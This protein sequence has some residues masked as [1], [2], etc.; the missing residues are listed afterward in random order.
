[1]RARGNDS[2]VDSAY[3]SPENALS[4]QTWLPL[5]LRTPPLREAISCPPRLLPTWTQPPY[6]T[7][8]MSHS[9]SMSSASGLEGLAGRATSSVVASPSRTSCHMA[10]ESYRW[11]WYRYDCGGEKEGSRSQEDRELLASLT[12]RGRRHFLGAVEWLRKIGMAISRTVNH[13]PP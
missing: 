13:H 10:S 3:S 1:M 4:Y 9:S 6:L 8:R 2:I 11:D 5:L 7:G 12:L